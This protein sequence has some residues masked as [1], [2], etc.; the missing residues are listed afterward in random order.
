MRSSEAPVY[1]THADLQRRYD[2]SRVWVWRQI[3]K[4]HFRELIKFGVKTSARRW[5]LVDVIAWEMER[6]KINGGAS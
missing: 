3:Q 4:N 1:F 5:Q 2:R 6:A